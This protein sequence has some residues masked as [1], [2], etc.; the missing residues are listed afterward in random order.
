MLKQ[1]DHTVYEYMHLLETGCNARRGFLLFTVNVVTTVIIVVVVV[2][3]V[4]TAV[5]AFYAECP[6]KRIY[7]TSTVESKT[8]FQGL[9][10]KVINSGSCMLVVETFDVVLFACCVFRRTKL[11]GQE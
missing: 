9:S 1:Q 6:S 3:V 10:V 7:L 8:R 11:Y 4:A 2:V 5:T